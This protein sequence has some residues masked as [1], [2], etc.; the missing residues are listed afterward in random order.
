MVLPTVDEDVHHGSDAAQEARDCACVGRKGGRSSQVISEAHDHAGKAEEEEVGHK[1]RCHRLEDGS[2]RIHQGAARL[3]SEEDVDSRVEHCNF[4]SCVKVGFLSLVPC[5]PGGNNQ[6]AGTNGNLLVVKLHSEI[7]GSSTDDGVGEADKESCK[8]KFYRILKQSN[9]INGKVKE[10]TIL[11]K[12]TGYFTQR[13]R[14]REMESTVVWLMW[15]PKR[16]PTPE[17]DEEDQA[18]AD[19]RHSKDDEPEDGEREMRVHCAHGRRSAW[20]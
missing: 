9:Y 15:M 8:R 12:R 5:V 6:A 2:L 7:S 16:S 4:S 18:V 3:A 17:D 20:K 13:N 14:S 10:Y 11:R 19:E 1:D